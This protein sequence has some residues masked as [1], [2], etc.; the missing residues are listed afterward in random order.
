MQT[1]FVL[2]YE[3]LS[4]PLLPSVSRRVCKLP[5]SG[6]NLHFSGHGRTTSYPSPSCALIQGLAAEP[7]LD[8]LLLDDVCLQLASSHFC[9]SV[10]IASC[11]FIFSSFSQ[12]LF[13]P[14]VLICSVY[15]CANSFCPKSWVLLTFP[16]PKPPILQGLT[17]PVNSANHLPYTL[18]IIS[19]QLFPN[20][21]AESADSL[22]FTIH[23]QIFPP[24]HWKQQVFLLWSAHSAVQILYNQI[25]VLRSGI[26]YFYRLFLIIQRFLRTGNK[27]M[28]SLNNVEKSMVLKKQKRRGK[29]KHFYPSQGWTD[30]HLCGNSCYY[31][32]EF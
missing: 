10:F 24:G 20:A 15:V 18:W 1:L 30:S 16:L 11:A 21:R 26:S 28:L 19:F 13:L 29:K 7:S 14:S 31:R 2:V 22:S 4:H 3:C 23:V 9:L 17:V 6:F 32:P 12:S 25:L 5:L 8:L 27:L